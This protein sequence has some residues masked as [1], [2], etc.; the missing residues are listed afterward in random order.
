[1]RNGVLRPFGNR[2]RNRQW[3]AREVFDL[4]AHF[5]RQVATL[6]ATT[7]PRGLVR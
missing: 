6:D 4:L 7:P 2:R 3:E 1:L 5:E